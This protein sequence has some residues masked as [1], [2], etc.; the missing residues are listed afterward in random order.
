MTITLSQ[1]K[2]IRPDIERCVQIEGEFTP[3]VSKD[4][5][6]FAMMDG[7]NSERFSQ[8]KSNMS[9]LELNNS[10]VECCRTALEKMPPMLTMNQFKSFELEVEKCMFDT[11]KHS[12]EEK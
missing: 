3:I 11:F 7:D 6:I 12:N 5:L 10:V 8:Y 1:L 9:R 4:R 2:S